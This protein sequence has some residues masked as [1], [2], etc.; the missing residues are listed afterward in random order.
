[1]ASINGKKGVISLIILAFISGLLGGVLAGLLFVVGPQGVRGIQGIQGIQ[2]PQGPRGDTGATGAT[3]P[4]GPA[5]ANGTTGATGATGPVGPT[6]PT[7]ATGATGPAGPAGATGATGATG[8]QGPQG[9]QG[10]PGEQGPQ[11][12]Q[13]EQGPQG[14]QGPQ[15]P[16]GPQGIQ[17]QPGLN[18]STSVIQI[19]QSQSANTS[20]LSAYTIGQWYNMSALDGSM[21]LT[22]NTQNQ[23]RIYA[24][25]LGTVS[26]SSG[27]AISLRIVV[28]NQITSTVSHAGVSGANV[29]LNL[30][31]QAKILTI[32]LPAGQHTIDVQ[33]LRNS[34]TPI[35][36]ERSLYVTE[37]A[38]P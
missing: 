17:G 19:I 37:L 7:G 32:A 29:A 24:E 20:D 31:V 3:G 30:T 11:G 25:F 28:D 36:M 2:G 35:L 5:G 10:I 13:G 38:F 34:G 26:I 9:E 4:A 1:M 18:G 27:G 22:I 12:I 33:F 16:P 23:S 6:G 8:A 14:I 21:R 15:G